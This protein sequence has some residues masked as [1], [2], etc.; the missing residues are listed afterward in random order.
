MKRLSK[1]AAR[2]RFEREVHEA[3]R[4]LINEVDLGSDYHFDILVVTGVIRE[5]QKMLNKRRAHDIP[6][7]VQDTENE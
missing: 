4:D 7:P 6:K 5:T 1:R 3:A 2:E